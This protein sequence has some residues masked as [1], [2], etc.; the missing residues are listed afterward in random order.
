MLVDEG[1]IGASLF[2]LTWVLAVWRVCAVPRLEQM[3]CVSLVASYF[4]I[5][6]SGSLEYHKVLWII[7]GLLLGMS[8][9]TRSLPP[10]PAA[11]PALS[12]QRPRLGSA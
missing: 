1:A 6:L 10:S 7:F 3:L 11:L 5:T 9:A 8:E 2:V 12:Y 4:P